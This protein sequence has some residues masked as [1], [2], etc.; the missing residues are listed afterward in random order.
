MI[1]VAIIG[2]GNVAYHLS[3]AFQT[4]EKVETSVF[5]GRTDLSKLIKNIDV[6]IIAVSDSAVIKVAKKLLNIDVLVAHT[7]GSVSINELPNKRKAVFYPLQTFSKEKKIDFTKIPLCI[8]TETKADFNTLNVLASSISN[9]VLKISSEQRKA[10]HAAAVFA[11]NFSNHM[12]YI[13]EDICKN[14]E[15]PFDLLKPL[16]HETADKINTVSPFD[17]QT[18]P[19]KRKDL[20]TIQEHEKFLKDSSHKLIYKQLTQSI[21][22]TY[23][24]KL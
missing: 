1:K 16:I 20:K 13:A 17:A 5:N 24:Q 14:N 7:S 4:N 23:G 9:T 8:E 11:N 19:A 22:N 21:L 12:Y 10:L 15:L 6:C 3:K 2:G 18:G